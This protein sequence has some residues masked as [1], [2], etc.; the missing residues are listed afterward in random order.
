MDRDYSKP[1]SRHFGTRLDNNHRGG[2]NQE[3]SKQYNNDFKQR[4]TT[5]GLR[6]GY[7]QG[8]Y[9]QGGYKGG[10]RYGG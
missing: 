2:Y 3:S 4:G 6:G 1:N 8:G 9:N 5:G 10:D 7:N